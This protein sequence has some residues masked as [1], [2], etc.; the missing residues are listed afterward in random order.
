MAFGQ[1]ARPLL[2]PAVTLLGVQLDARTG[3]GERSH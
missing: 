1:A 2:E 3:F